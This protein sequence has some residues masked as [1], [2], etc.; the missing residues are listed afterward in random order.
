MIDM[1]ASGASYKRVGREFHHGEYRIRD[2]IYRHAPGIMRT[3]SEQA[4]LS[5]NRFFCLEDLDQVEIG[6]CAVCGIEL[7]GEKKTRALQT[8]GLCM[9][10]GAT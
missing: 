1:Y 3:R 6:P 4:N 7:V 2:M 10:A 9:A 5:S 8:C